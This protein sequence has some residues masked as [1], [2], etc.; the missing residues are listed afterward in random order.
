MQRYPVR[1]AQM[2]AASSKLPTKISVMDFLLYDSG[3]ARLSGADYR[4]ASGLLED[5]R[6]ARHGSSFVPAYRR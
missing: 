5:W 3:S 4:F 1:S 6:R 2:V